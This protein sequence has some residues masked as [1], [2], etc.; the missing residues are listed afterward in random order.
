MKKRIGGILVGVLLGCMV[1][2]GFLLKINIDNWVE[3]HPELK[4]P[5]RGLPVMEIS[6]NGVSLEE[7]DGGSK[8]AKYE[9]N[10]LDL[11]VGGE[12]YEYD[13]VE[14]K[15]RGNATWAQDKKPYQIKFEDKTEL[16]GLG[17]ARKWYLLANAL[18]TT[19]IRTE[20]AF[21][22]EEILDMKYR[23]KG[24]FVELYIDGDYRGLYYLTRAVEISKDL[25]DLRDPLG[26][27]VELDNVYGKK[28]EKYY[29][30]GNGDRLVVKD[31]VSKD[32]VDE[33]MREFLWN[34]NELEVAVKEKNYA[35]VEELADVES[36][37]EYYL[38]SEFTVDPDAYWTSFYLNKDGADDKIHA[39]PGWDFDLA[40]KNR[41]WGNW[42]GEKFYSPTEKM[43]RRGELLP[44]EFYQENGME[45]EYY[46]SLDLSRII[47]GL[48]EFPE[49]Q[50]EVKRIY[51]ER[52]SGRKE[53]LIEVAEK[54]AK[55]I[56]SAVMADEEKWEGE[57]FWEET[58]ELLEW[59]RAR[60]DYF[61]EEY[62]DVG[63]V[64]K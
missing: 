61:E 1:L 26:V 51:Q 55:E 64:T 12:A 50:E 57:G 58:T 18:D 46:A 21:Y 9:G 24:E 52:M 23:F 15:G 29:V 48:M 30:T 33:A 20:V 17:K 47:Y 4:Y 56:E 19:N 5:N 42:M 37:A 28:E 31:E 7:I 53:E 38:L 59:M 14:V 3:R 60:Y 34:Y 10:E 22:L 8:E 45:K 36:F 43:V 40:L 16:L 32:K 44:L 25:V 2:L 49:F 13:G 63:D 54:T 27:L 6:L 11:Y 41:N 39:G 35:K 62:G